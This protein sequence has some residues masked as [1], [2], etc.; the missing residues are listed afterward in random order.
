MDRVFK[1]VNVEIPE[2]IIDDRSRVLNLSGQWYV[3]FDRVGHAGSVRIEDLPAWSHA[4]V[5]RSLTELFDLPGDWVGTATY[6]LL[7]RMTTPLSHSDLHNKAV[8]LNMAGVYPEAKIF[9][10]GRRVGPYKGGICAL[11]AR[12]EDFLREEENL[13]LVQFKRGVYKEIGDFELSL[14]FGIWGP[15]WLEIRPKLFI[16]SVDVTADCEGNWESHINLSEPPLEPLQLAVRLIDPNRRILFRT[17]LKVE[18]PFLSF[19]GP[20]VREVY[21]WSPQYPTLYTLELVLQGKEADRKVVPFGFRTLQSSP[22]GFLLNGKLLH[23]RG[24][25]DEVCFPKWG[26]TPPSLSSLRK[27][28]EIVKRLGFNTLVVEDA[29]ADLRLPLLADRMGVLL[30]YQLPSVSK[31]VKRAA[32]FLEKLLEAIQWRDGNS[33]S[34]FAVNL[35]SARPTKNLERANKWAEEKIGKYNF[36]VFAGPCEELSAL[37]PIHFLKEDIAQAAVRNK[38][39]RILWGIKILDPPRRECAIEELGA[40]KAFQQ[41]VE[42]VQRERLKQAI[43]TV[44]YTHL[45]LPTKA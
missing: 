15:V 8:I 2:A 22:E 34:L 11:R 6:G 24:V 28:L 27:R 21:P 4:P 35:F 14:P 9:L 20:K 45:T 36:Y 3:T 10:N 42:K 12:I 1:D 30:W 31:F 18:E 41:A 17:K 39:P 44:S 26:R 7:F 13:L 19:R 5:P 25:V 33:P 43:D 16:E 38:A 23:I 37:T 29:P 40:G 32:T